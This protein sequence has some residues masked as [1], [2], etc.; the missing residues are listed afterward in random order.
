MGVRGKGEKKADWQVCKGKVTTPGCLYNHRVIWESDMNPE[1]KEGNWRRAGKP[2]TE[3]R[4]LKDLKSPLVKTLYWPLELSILQKATS[5]AWD[6]PKKKKKQQYANHHNLS[7]S[8]RWE[9]HDARPLWQH[10]STAEERSFIYLQFKHKRLWN[11][12]FFL[13]DSVKRKLYET[14]N[15]ECRILLRILFLNATVVFQVY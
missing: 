5:G 3:Q 10:L 4:W 15:I 8:K 6:R 11:N 2:L 14:A 13:T 1:K 12:L 9:E 7:I